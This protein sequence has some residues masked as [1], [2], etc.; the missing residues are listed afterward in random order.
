V[1]VG[2]R[3]LGEMRDQAR[4]IIPPDRSRWTWPRAPV[5]VMLT[6]EMHVCDPNENTHEREDSQSRTEAAGGSGSIASGTEGLQMSEDTRQPWWRRTVTVTPGT[7]TLLGIASGSSLGILVSLPSFDYFFFMWLILTFQGGVW[8][9]IIWL[10]SDRARGERFQK[11]ASL[12]AAVV[13]IVLLLAF[14]E[15]WRQVHRSEGWIVILALFGVINA[16]SM[17]VV[18]AIWGVIQ[19]LGYLPSLPRRVL[20]ASMNSPFEGVWDRELDY[21]VPVVKHIDRTIGEWLRP[22]AVP[23]SEP[24]SIKNRNG[25]TGKSRGSVKGIGDVGR[26]NDWLVSF[27]T[28]ATNG[29]HFPCHAEPREI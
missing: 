22:E 16:A 21:E 4:Q 11:I 8:G 28:G 25:D 12:V 1:P 9:Y 20:K 29:E 2:N 26:R 13:I 3:I 14:P 24:M 17:C 10:W 27:P 7:A 23:G 19:L 6:P 18:G 5:H 15:S